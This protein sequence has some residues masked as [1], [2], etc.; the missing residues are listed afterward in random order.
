MPRECMVNRRFPPSKCKLI[1][2]LA[3]LVLNHHYL[4]FND[5]YWRQIRRTA[6]NSNFAVVYACLFL[7][8]Q[9][10]QIWLCCNLFE[11]PYMLYYK[12]YIDDAFGIWSGPKWLLRQFLGVYGTFVDTIKI[13]HTISDTT[14]D[15]LDI[16]FFK[17]DD[18]NRTC[19]LSTR[20]HQKVQNKYQHLPWF[21]WHPY[22]QKKVFL[23]GKLRRYVLRESTNQGF[24]QN[25]L[26]FQT[27]FAPPLSGCRAPPMLLQQQLVP[28]PFSS[29]MAPFG[30]CKS[31]IQIP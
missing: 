27:N 25:M 15:I 7:C 10:E 24:N 28:I 26:Y 17:S 30:N 11:D 16:I 6:M 13:T 21:S 20:C 22:H 12:C 14:A 1:M 3:S 19:R 9:E 4:E 18:F 5:T 8:V 31:G 29:I 2:S 23:V